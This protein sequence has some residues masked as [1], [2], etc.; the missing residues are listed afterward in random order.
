MSLEQT[1]VNFGLLLVNLEQTLV[2][3]GL[4][5]VSLEQILVSFGLLLVISEQFDTQNFNTLILP[6]S[7]SKKAAIKTVIS[8]GTFVNSCLVPFGQYAPVLFLQ[9]HHT[10]WFH[11]DFE[12]FRNLNS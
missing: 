9:K 2:S 10:E 7:S 1:L 8:N 6:C 12:S 3:F 4:L 11:G 5:L